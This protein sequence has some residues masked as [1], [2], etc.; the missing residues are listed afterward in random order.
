MSKTQKIKDHKISKIEQKLK[1]NRFLLRNLD[2]IRKVLINQLT[3]IETQIE[4]Q[5]DELDLKEYKIELDS[6][7]LEDEKLWLLNYEI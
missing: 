6:E 3:K 4:T 2:T 5:L 1:E 7:K